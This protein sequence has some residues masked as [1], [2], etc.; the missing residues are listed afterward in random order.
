MQKNCCNRDI[1]LEPCSKCPEYKTCVITMSEE[2]KEVFEDKEIIAE[3]ESSNNEFIWRRT[4][5]NWDDL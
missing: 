5:D 3:K 1:L 2:I 4:I